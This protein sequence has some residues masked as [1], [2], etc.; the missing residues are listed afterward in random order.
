M[1]KKKKKKK[2][3]KRCYALYALSTSHRV[4]VEGH[5]LS[6]ADAEPAAEPAAGVEAAAAAP[7]LLEERIVFELRVGGEEDVEGLDEVR[8][9]LSRGGFDLGVRGDVED[10]AHHLGLLREIH[11]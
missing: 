1:K 8:V 5:A 2:K 6:L 9:A 7:A 11:V 4:S 3:K 10:G